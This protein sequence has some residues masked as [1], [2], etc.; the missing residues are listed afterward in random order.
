MKKTQEN[1]VQAGRFRA[2]RL[3]SQGKFIKKPAS[4]GD[5]RSEVLSAKK[6]VG[7]NRMGWFSTPAQSRPST[8]AAVQVSRHTVQQHMGTLQ[9]G[10]EQQQVGR[11]YAEKK[12]GTPT[13]NQTFTDVHETDKRPADIQTYPTKNT[14]RRAH[15]IAQ[16]AA[17]AN[18]Y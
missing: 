14:H 15:R 11:E 13:E 8:G 2:I 1:T 10:H 3:H 9:D 12:R 4:P 16:L 6:H 7:K 5:Q 17:Q 18:T